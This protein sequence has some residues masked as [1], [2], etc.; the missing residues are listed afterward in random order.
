MKIFPYLYTKVIK[1]LKGPLN[2]WAKL[3]NYGHC[4]WTNKIHKLSLAFAWKTAAQV[5]QNNIVIVIN[6]IAVRRAN[7]IRFQV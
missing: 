6:Q 4:V 3:R 7:L 5:Y 2:F 1:K